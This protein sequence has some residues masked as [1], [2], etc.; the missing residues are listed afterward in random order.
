GVYFSIQKYRESGKKYGQLLEL[1]TKN[2]SSARINND[3]YDKESVHDFALW[4]VTK[5]GEPAWEFTLDGKD[6]LGRPGWHIEC[7]VMSTNNLG[8][9]F[10][11][12]TGGIDLIFPH[13]ENEI[14][15]STAGGGETYA[16]YFVH[17][18][19]LL[20]DGK[21]MSK[22]LSN[23]FTLRDIQER[24]YDPLD[25]R[26]MMLQAHYR[27]QTNFTWDNLDAAHNRLQAYRA[28][29]DQRFQLH[30]EGKVK[31]T[32]IEQTKESI[33]QAL[34]SDLN[35][36]L[37]LKHLSEIESSIDSGGINT[38]CQDAYTNFLEWLDQTLGLNLSSRD[39]ITEAQ[40]K[41]LDERQHARNNKAWQTADSLRNDLRLQ[42]IEVLD[43]ELG[44]VW[45]YLDS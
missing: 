35:T 11:I 28:M 13:H 29:A 30:K 37:A 26:L 7:S 10:D 5:P 40:K 31:P 4:K 25:F 43:T 32:D 36:P 8:M 18:E 15:Q 39:D 21:K 27:S 2:T 19:H 42:G 20:V 6:L 45:K 22:S 12:H 14:A 33:T 3:E 9:P 34:L 44:Q 38:T 41:L 23:F 16:K 24:G 1:D 17:N